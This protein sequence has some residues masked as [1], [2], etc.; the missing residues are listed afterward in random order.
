MARIVAIDYG[1]KRTGLAVTDPLQLIATPLAT[2]D[3]AALMDYLKG[4]AGKEAVEC[5]VVGYPKNLD[6]TPAEAARYV[7]PFLLQ[8]RKQ[9]PSVNVA[10]EDERFTSKIAFRAMIDGGVKKKDRRNKAMIDRVS[11]VI[12]LQSYLE[13]KQ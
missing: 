2:V 8:L 9:F 4:Y 11:A 6:N 12:I 13:R 7:D 5:F 10:L 1:L 3:T